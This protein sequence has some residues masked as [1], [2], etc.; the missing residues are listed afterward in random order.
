MLV[1]LIG[2][3]KYQEM[4]MDPEKNGHSEIYTGAATFRN[5][6][7]KFEKVYHKKPYN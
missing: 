7:I 3:G 4:K 5:L 1:I 6:I 2:H